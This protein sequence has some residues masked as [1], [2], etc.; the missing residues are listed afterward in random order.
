[1]N[2]AA[3]LEGPIAP[4]LLRMAWPVL[5]VLALQTLV[6]V[7][8]TWF[9]SFLGTA[10]IAGVALVFPVFMLMVM[11]SNG[12]MGGG[13][14]AAIARAIGAGRAKD[15]EALVL[16][17]VVIAIGFGIL[18]M[19]GAWIGGPALYRALG[20]Q[21]ETLQ[22]ALL[23]SNLIFASAI[24]AWIANLMGSALRGA[25]NVRVPAITTTAGAVGTLALSPLLIFGWGPVP[26]FGVA[27]AGYAMIVFNVASAVALALYLRSSRSPLR[28]ALAPLERR[29]FGDILRVGLISAVGT[30]VSNLTVVLT[31][32]FVGRR[33]A[34]AIAGYGIA[35]RIDYALIPLL[36]A[37]GTAAVTMVGTNVGAGNRERARRIA[38]TSAIASVIAVETIGIAATLFAEGWMRLF[39]TE[40]AVVRVGVEYLHIVAPFYGF[41]GLGMALYF[42]SQGAGSMSWP[43]AAGLSRLLTVGAAGAAWITLAHGSLAPLFWGVAIAQVLFGGINAF[44]VTRAAAWRPAVPRAI[45]PLGSA[46]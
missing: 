4:T 30:I 38:S 9:V 23:Y 24:P 39:S 41:T 12:G 31:A 6:G 32:G 46:P 45:T 36:F 19:L 26:G 33:G 27:G 43:F 8:E 18:F 29:L 20:A 25:G 10:A 11:M 3:L 40:A 34:E 1:M 14:S 16:H 21:G 22:N 2:R 42:A 7:A 37:I 13:V 15:A 44:G 17:A 28:L 5:A 35:S